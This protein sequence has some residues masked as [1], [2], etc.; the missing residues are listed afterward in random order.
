MAEWELLGGASRVS[1][2]PVPEGEA[3]FDITATEIRYLE[4]D[5]KNYDN[6]GIKGSSVLKLLHAKQI[7]F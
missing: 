2:G 7:L 4:K 3:G 6:T 5:C 1:L